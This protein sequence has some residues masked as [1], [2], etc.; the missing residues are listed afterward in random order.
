MKKITIILLSLLLLPGC[1]VS[2]QITT[3]I[4][5]PDGSAEVIVVRS[6]IHFRGNDEKREEEQEEYRRKF[7]DGEQFWFDRIQTS[8]GTIEETR[9]IK[10][11]P[12]MANYLRGSLPNQEAV[13]KLLT[14]DNNWKIQSNI[15]TDGSTRTL[16][17]TVIPPP[18]KK[19]S[20]PPA[21]PEKIRKK[22]ANS[23]SHTRIAIQNGKI[24]E[25]EGF[26]VADDGQS[27]LV[28][29]GAFPDRL[30][31]ENAGVELLLSWKHN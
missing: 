27:A 25:A 7:N 24:I 6:N 5:Q 17:V 13:E 11:T 3:L 16:K 19:L 10:Q 1:I 8:G 26:M 9:W 23:I 31:K 14:L 4:I 18:D 15:T 22:L 20:A 12:P 28:D 29:E 2:D 30:W 21:D